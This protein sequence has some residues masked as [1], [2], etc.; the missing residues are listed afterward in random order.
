[1]KI[2]SYIVDFKVTPE[3][4]L[5]RSATLRLCPVIKAISHASGLFKWDVFY[6]KPNKNCRAPNSLI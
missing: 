4:V 2:S 5:R 6:S 1:M 3:I